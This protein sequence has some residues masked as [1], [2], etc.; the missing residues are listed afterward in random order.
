M[1]AKLEMAQDRLI[2]GVSRMSDT[3][4][5]NRFVI[6]LYVLL[7]L[8]DKPLCLDEM[9]NVLGVSKGSVS[10]NIRELEKWGAVKNIWIKG[11]RKDYYRAESDIKKVFITKIVLAIEKRSK[12]ISFILEEFSQMLN[13]LN[14]DL[15]EEEKKIA[16]TYATKL[17]EI[18]RMR[19]TVVLVADMMRKII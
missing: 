2:E 3:F 13:S 5:L 16:A 1:N 15:N 14:G 6:Q 4:G 7:Y 17:D 9:A 10:V 19:D 11:S 12:D 8:Q 18:K